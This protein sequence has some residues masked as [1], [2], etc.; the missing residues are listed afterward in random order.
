MHIDIY[1]YRHIRVCVCAYMSKV[2]SHF[3][4]IVADVLD[5][6]NMTDAAWDDPARHTT[7]QA[8]LSQLLGE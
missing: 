5:R 3:S 1:I 2:M 4:K 6:S 7:L 8:E